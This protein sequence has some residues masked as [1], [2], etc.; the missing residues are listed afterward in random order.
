MTARR[1]VCLLGGALFLC[2]PATVVLWPRSPVVT[3]TMLPQPREDSRPPKVTL[4]LTN[5]VERHFSFYYCVEVRT[6]NGWSDADSQPEGA[7]V[8]NWLRS[9]TVET[10]ELEGPSLSAGW[11]VRCGY[12]PAA[13]PLSLRVVN[14]LDAVEIRLANRFGFRYRDLVSPLRRWPR[15]VF[16]EEFEVK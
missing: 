1:I 9:H 7:R 11:R 4:R 10:V 15:H 13:T 5:R 8:L 16:S 14:R 6:S 2:L 3:V 12:L